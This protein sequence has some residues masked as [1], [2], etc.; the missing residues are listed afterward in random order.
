MRTPAT[1][2][3]AG[4]IR[5]KSFDGIRS[6]EQF[7]NMSYPG[8]PIGHIWSNPDG[9]PPTPDGTPPY[10]IHQSLIPCGVPNCKEFQ[11][12]VPPRDPS[13]TFCVATGFNPLY[14]DGCPLCPQTT[15]LPIYH[16][17]LPPPN[18]HFVTREMPLFTKERFVVNRRHVPYPV[19]R[20]GKASG[21]EAIENLN[22]NI[23]KTLKSKDTKTVNKHPV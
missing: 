7:S 19:Q 5:H 6:K 3:T 1:G 18:S 17:K 21:I 9:L 15:H 16:Q 13:R 8:K 10:Q 12:P 23:P 4:H 2:T 14:S 22:N 20:I 11:I